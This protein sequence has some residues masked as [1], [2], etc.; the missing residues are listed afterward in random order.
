MKRGQQVVELRVDLPERDV[1]RMM[2]CGRNGSIRPQIREVVER[3]LREAR[4]L[5]RPCGTY[6]LHDVVRMTDEELALRD[7]PVIRGPVAAFL[8]P[9][10]RV[11]AFVVTVGPEL[12]KMSAQRLAAGE[13]LEGYTLNAIGSAAA[14]L[15]ADAMADHIFWNDAASDEGITPPFSPGYCG[16]SL[17]EQKTLFSIVD[18]GAVGV[19][20]WPTMIME[21][22]KSVSGLIGLGP[23]DEVVEH[24]VPCQW[25]ELHACK[26][27]RDARSMPSR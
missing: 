23:R 1:L 4:D 8:K 2:G 17:D 13:T 10:R 5:L 14:D 26:M 22:V 9:A 25:C 18:G 12:E 15:A 19:K 20:L 11:A 24:G 21:P 27:R 7:C 3:V 16:L 6:V